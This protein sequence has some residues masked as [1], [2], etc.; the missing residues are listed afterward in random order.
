MVNVFTMQWRAFGGRVIFLASLLALLSGGVLK[1]ELVKECSETSMSIAH[2]YWGNWSL[3]C[4]YIGLILKSSQ[5]YRVVLS[6]QVVIFKHHHNVDF[7][8]YFE[9]VGNECRAGEESWE[10]HVDGDVNA[11]THITLSN[12]DV[13]DLGSITGVALGTAACLYPH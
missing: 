9:V 11:S 2:I 12:L 8:F 6:H 10:D 3:E 7:K 1:V 4:I 13:L 5:L